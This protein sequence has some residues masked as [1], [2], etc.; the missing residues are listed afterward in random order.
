M[1]NYEDLPLIPL[2]PEQAVLCTD[3][4]PKI[5][6]LD[7]PA[8]TVM[9]N[10][11]HTP[12]HTISMEASIDDALNEMKI[13][14]VH[15]LFVVD[16]KEQ[17]KGL[18]ASEDILG[19]LPIKIIQD[20]RIPRSKIRVKMVMVPLKKMIA[21]D[22]EDVDRAKVGNIVNTL[23]SQSKHYALAI[24]KDRKK[25]IIRGIFAS[26]HITRQLHTEIMNST[27]KTQ[28]VSDLQKQHED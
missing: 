3:V 5:T 17:A 25:E 8:T 19:E 24:K 12:A 14:G 23:K 10:F 27:N 18:I 4:L 16:E 6:H 21:F 20:R 11:A 7:D 9:I 2:S 22:I 26:A 28:S 13:H 15:L 1:V